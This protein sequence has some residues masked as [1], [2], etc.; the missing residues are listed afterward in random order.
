M[1]LPWFW[2]APCT[3][4]NCFLYGVI[5]ACLCHGFGLHRVRNVTVFFVVSVCV[6]G[7][8]FC[9]GFGLHCVHNV[10]VSFVVSV[11]VIGVFVPWFCCT[12]YTM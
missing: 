4:C 9:H 1:F 2:S 11:C 12:V 3:Q 7:V 8:C 10:T 6:I 5:G